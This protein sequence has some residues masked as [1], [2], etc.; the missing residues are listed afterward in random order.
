MVVAMESDGPS[1]IVSHSQTAAVDGTTEGRLGGRQR[2]TAKGDGRRGLKSPDMYTSAKSQGDA[3]R[4]IAV[5]VNPSG[6]TWSPWLGFIARGSSA[7]VSAQILG[8]YR[9]TSNRAFV[10]PPTTLV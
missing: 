10:L 7:R 9:L 3:A 8:Y 2:R 6:M 1:D 5:Q 4:H